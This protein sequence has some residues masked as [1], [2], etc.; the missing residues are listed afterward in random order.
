MFV[1]C[2]GANESPTGG[3][4]W[5][6]KDLYEQAEEK[7]IGLRPAMLAECM[8]VCT[9]QLSI[10]MHG[11]MYAVLVVASDIN[12]RNGNQCQSTATCTLASY[13][14]YTYPSILTPNL[15]LL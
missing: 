1:Y 15:I 3:Y 10:F 11:K 8:H 7:L 4:G 12:G 14:G 13:R 9:S 2:M 6:P 5:A